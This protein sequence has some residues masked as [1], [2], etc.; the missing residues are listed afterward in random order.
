M[1]SNGYLSVPSQH[2]YSHNS[3]SSNYPGGA[4]RSDA[5]R[6]GPTRTMAL[7]GSRPRSF[8]L[9]SPLYDKSLHERHNRDA[10][11][12]SYAEFCNNMPPQFDT[13]KIH[14]RNHDTALAATLTQLDNFLASRNIC[15]NYMLRLCSA[16]KCGCVHDAIFRDSFIA[17]LFGDA[18][19]DL[20]IASRGG[21]SDRCFPR[22]D[23]GRGIQTNH[24]PEFLT[25]GM[26]EDQFGPDVISFEPSRA[27][28]VAAGLYVPSSIPATRAYAGAS[29]E[30]EF[31]KSELQTE[32]YSED[33]RHLHSLAEYS[34]P[35][36][37]YR[38]R[39]RRLGIVRDRVSLWGKTAWK[40]SAVPKQTRRTNE[41][42]VA[43]GG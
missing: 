35:P 28:N 9:G 5:I 31:E 4:C 15:R 24:G 8:S 42:E 16:P 25:H 36:R 6:S 3:P 14:P 20:R 13:T 7:H 19:G 22:N 43:L 33:K 30:M 18:W 12:Q 34:L 40:K 37:P 23:T 38:R 39:G 32:N 11:A 10:N 2:Q 26:D 1:A 17:P 21:P 27:L 29:T 41:K